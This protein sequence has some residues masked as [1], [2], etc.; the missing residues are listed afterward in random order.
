MLIIMIWHS[1][2]QTEAV[3]RVSR[4]IEEGLVTASRA[5][6]FCGVQIRVGM[7]FLYHAQTVRHFL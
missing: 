4:E 2:R 1:L 3:N 5:Q 6:H 7:M